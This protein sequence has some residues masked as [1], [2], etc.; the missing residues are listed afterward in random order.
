MSL[1]IS[2]PAGGDQRLRLWTSRPFE[3]GRSKLLYG[4]SSDTES[5]EILKFGLRFRRKYL[6]RKSGN[7]P[8]WRKYLRRQNLH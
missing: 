1:G 2:P 6:R 5:A 8:P 3:K 4:V 7:L